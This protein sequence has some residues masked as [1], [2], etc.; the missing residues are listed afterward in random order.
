MIKT[1]FRSLEQ[2]PSQGSRGHTCCP[3]LL[4]RERSGKTALAPEKI[5]GGHF[6]CVSAPVGASKYLVGPGFPE[7]VFC[8]LARMQASSVLGARLPE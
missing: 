7:Q 5:A 1:F 2:K 8:N 3:V 4:S 6:Y